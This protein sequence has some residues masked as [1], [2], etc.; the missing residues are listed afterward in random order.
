MRHLVDAYSVSERRACRTL[1]L[2]RSSVRYQTRSRDDE[3]LRER[4]RDLAEERPR[5]G[6]RRLHVL[7]KREMP[8]INHKRVYRLY[9]EENLAIRRRKRKR[10]ARPRVPMAPPEVANELWTMDFVHDSLASGRSFRALTVLDAHT[11]ECLAIEVDTSLPGARVA[12]V[13]DRIGL[14]RGLPNAIRIDNG[15]EFAGQALDAW[16]YRNGVTLDFITPGRP[17]ENAFV[18]S[19]NGKFRDECLNQHWF[20]SLRDAQQKIERWR[21]DYN[22]VRPHSSLDDQ[23]PSEFAGTISEGPGLSLALDQ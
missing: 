23:T 14:F 15:P 20:L 3:A 12:R 19:F 5:W 4:L 1:E 2:N 16:A 7:L 18:E 8:P 17:M 9:R 22:H 6:Y 21:Q 13:L 10:V 11:R